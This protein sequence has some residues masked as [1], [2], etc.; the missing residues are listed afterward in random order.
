MGM[1][2]TARLL[3]TL[4]ASCLA[5]LGVGAALALPW[6][7]VGALMMVPF[8]ATWYFSRA[9]TL[10]DTPEPEVQSVP[11]PSGLG[12]RLLHRMPAPL[13]V[14]GSNRRLTYANPAALDLLPNAQPGGHFSTMVRAPAFVDA[15]ETILREEEDL[16]FAF[17]MVRS[18]GDLFLEARASFLPPAAAQEF[19]EGA[20]IIIQ[21][22][23]RTR[24]KAVLQTRSDFVANASHELRTPLASILGY[25]ETL[26]G[27]A[28]EDPEARE[29]FL[30]IM[31]QQAQRMQRMVDDLM[32]LSRIEMNA[33]VKPDRRLDFFAV[34]AEAANA[35]FP[36]ATAADVLLQIELPLSEGTGPEVMGDRDQLA[37]VVTNLIDNAIKY[38]GRGEKVRVTVAEPDPRFPGQVGVS[39]I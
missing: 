35:L 24:D 37:Q 15:I 13:M 8:G 36:Q 22:E 31:M 5:V 38:G 11:L 10:R 32:S 12:R 25:I 16:R 27:H 26:Q 9:S 34:V 29:L 39:V 17:S 7:A 14:I 28:K 4:C 20:Q 6:P 30:G 18:G 2:L 33:H 21:I 1:P 3:V 23:D 19:G